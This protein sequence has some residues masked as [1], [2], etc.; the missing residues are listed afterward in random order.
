MSSG[1]FISS[2]SGPQHPDLKSARF[3]D[4]R[5]EIV[6]AFDDVLQLQGS[7]TKWPHLLLLRSYHLELDWRT[8]LVLPTMMAIVARVDN[9]LFVGLPLCNSVCLSSLR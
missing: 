5:D 8:L 4:V 7:G 3:P 1:K 9:R 6:C 2:T